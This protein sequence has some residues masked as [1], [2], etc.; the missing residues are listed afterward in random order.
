MGKGDNKHV[1]IGAAVAGIIAFILVIV[2]WATYW[3]YQDTTPKLFASETVHER[4]YF[5]YYTETGGGSTTYPD[6]SQQKKIFSASLSFLTIGGAVL[7][8]F[9]V[10][11]LLRA[12]AF[13][14]SSIIKLLT[15]GA[16][17]AAVVL[18]MISFFTFLGINKAFDS[19]YDGICIGGDNSSC[20]KFMGSFSNAVW[21][22][23]WGGGPGFWV[24]LVAIVLTLGATLSALKAAC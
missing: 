5:T 18:L 10:L 4:Y 19:D 16:G 17:I 24:L 14:D 6:N 9:I 20:K 2:S 1:H 21:T 22:I 12:F 7:L 3:Y 13:Q 23:K 8:G 11:I 15:L